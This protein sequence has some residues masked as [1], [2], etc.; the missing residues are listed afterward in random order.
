[1]SVTRHPLVPGDPGGHIDSVPLDLE[2]IGR[3]ES[4]FAQVSAAGDEFPRRFYDALFA[5]HPGLRRMFP[6]DMAPQRTKLLEMLRWVVATLRDPATVRS[7]LAELG[8]RHV[9]YGARA[10]HY[11]AV[12]QA[13][14]RAMATTCGAAWSPELEHEWTSA[15][16]LVSE[17]MLAGPQRPV[18]RP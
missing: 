8:A 3:L 4:S 1:M 18:P 13:L 15:L 2:L 7:Q 6:T 5:A 11:P 12:V 9:G 10:E 16:R 17:I 14:V